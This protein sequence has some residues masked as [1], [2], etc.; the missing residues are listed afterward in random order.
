MKG[1]INMTV[2]LG[3]E[4]P[5]F[6]SIIFGENG[7][8]V[9]TRNGDKVLIR[10]KDGSIRTT[11]VDTFMQCLAAAL[12]KIKEQPKSDTFGGKS[13]TDSFVK[14][15][16][17]NEDDNPLIKMGKT[18]TNMT[19]LEQINEND[20]N[21]EKSRKRMHNSF[22]MLYNPFAFREKFSNWEKY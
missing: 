14:A 10:G 2:G 15:E 19:K 1:E 7:K 3:S 22:A 5:K 21:W 20:S 13:F 6:N 12:P 17:I 8:Y 9:A 4:C 16:K 11:D 18:L